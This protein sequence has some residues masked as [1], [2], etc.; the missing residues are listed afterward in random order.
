MDARLERKTVLSSLL[1]IPATRARRQPLY[2]EPPDG[3]SQ[4][5]DPWEVVV[6]DGI[7]IGKA[8]FV[9]ASG[10]QYSS[11]EGSR[12]MSGTIELKW[13]PGTHILY[14]ALKALESCFEYGLLRN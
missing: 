1:R 2:A 4:G 14:L 7:S 8:V 10:A 13:A 9:P 12:L 6:V 5:Q 11:T 3:I